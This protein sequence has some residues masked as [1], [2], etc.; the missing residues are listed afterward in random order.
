MLKRNHH[1]NSLDLNGSKI[2]TIYLVEFSKLNGM[3]TGCN[4]KIKEQAQQTHGKTRNSWKSSEASVSGRYKSR[5]RLTFFCRAC[6]DVIW[7]RRDEIYFI[8]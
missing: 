3:M 2:H 7:S 5:G 8:V 6:C 1:V 4:A